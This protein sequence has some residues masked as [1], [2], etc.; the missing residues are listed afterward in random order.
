MIDYD[1]DLFVTCTTISIRILNV[2]LELV[3]VFCIAHTNPKIR[4]LISNIKQVH[5]LAMQIFTQYNINLYQE[6]IKN[7]LVFDQFFVNTTSKYLWHPH[8][9]LLL[10][11]IFANCHYICQMLLYIHVSMLLDHFH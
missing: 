6:R 1:V 3:F 10:H 5:S 9:F 7:W 4:N 8:S 11:Q 2:T